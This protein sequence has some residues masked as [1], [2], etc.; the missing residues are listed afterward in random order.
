[1]TMQDNLKIGTHRIAAATV[2]LALDFNPDQAVRYLKEL[3][4][5]NSFFWYLQEFFDEGYRISPQDDEAAAKAIR[6]KQMKLLNDRADALGVE[7]PAIHRWLNGAIDLHRG[8]SDWKQELGFD[9]TRENLYNLCGVLGFDQ[10]KTESFFR[11]AAF[12]AP[13]N[14]KSW[15]ELVYQFYISQS[16][17]SWYADSIKLISEIE[18]ERDQTQESE[19]KIFGTYKVDAELA[20]FLKMRDTE[21][22]KEELKAFV[23]KN[24]STFQ[25]ENFRYTAYNEILTLYEDCKPY[26]YGELLCRREDMS[27]GEDDIQAMEEMSP[28]VLFSEILNEGATRSEGKNGL[29]LDSIALP[30]YA[31][32]K[33]KEL[34]KDMVKIQHRIDTVEKS[35]ISD[36]DFVSDARLRKLLLLLN[37]YYRYG[38][39]RQDKC[40]KEHRRHPEN[41]YSYTKDRAA[42]YSGY[43]EEFCD[44]TNASLEDAGFCSLYEGN[45]LDCLFLLA[46]HTKQPIAALREIIRTGQV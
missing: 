9:P 16:P 30:K 39:Y 35:S 21:K 15:R 32:L 12:F 33:R 19:S 18:Q 36:E 37:F 38:R 40:G 20:R 42:D 41:G 8:K 26:V 23:L 4:Q 22:A 5:T 11:R 25:P 45:A 34:S 14:R 43:F 3:S 2:D 29:S 24:W 46:A 1:M 7:A 44:E 27:V 10:K 6:R 13:W 31:Q 17:E 28:Y